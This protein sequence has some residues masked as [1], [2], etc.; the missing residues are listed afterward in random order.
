MAEKNKSH[1][2][3]PVI[4]GY[5]PGAARLIHGEKPKSAWATMKRLTCYLKNDWLL[6]SLAI[7]ASIAVTIFTTYNMRLMGIA[8]DEF[9]VQYNPQGLANIAFTMAIIFT[10]TSFLTYF[11]MRLMNRVSQKVSAELRAD[12]FRSFLC[13]PL[14]FFDRRSSGELMSRLTNDVDN[15]NQTLASGLSS[16]VEAIVNILAMF[17][18]MV[19]LSPYLTAWAMLV[20]PLTF[21]STRIVVS[22]SRRF[23]KTLQ[24]DLGD[25]NAYIE[26]RLSAQKMLILFDQAQT[27]VKGFQR[28]NDKLQI[29]YQNAQTLSALAP[30]MSFINNSI[31]FLVTVVAARMILNGDPMTVGILFT[32]L[33]YMRRFAQPLNQIAS[34]FNSIQSAI[35]GAERIFEIIDTDSEFRDDTLPYV[36]KNGHIA[37]NHVYFSYDKESPVLYDISM[38]IKPGSTLAIVGSTGSGKTTI[39]SLLNRFYD[40]DSG[41]VYLDDQDTLT[42]DH[43]SLRKQVGLVLQDTFLFSDSIRENIRYGCKHASNEDVEKAAEAT[44]AHRFISHLPDGYETIIQENG[45]GLSQGQR[46][47][48]AIS[49]AILSDAPI[50]VLD[51]ATSSID[52][53]TEQEVQEALQTLSSG[54]T[55]LVIAHRL[56]TIRNADRILVLDN[57]R[58]VESGQHDELLASNGIYAAMYRSQFPERISA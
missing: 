50:L 27:T 49:R 20:I 37:Y 24:E 54:K 14:S 32:F 4:G 55:T 52:T 51:E 41:H 10:S 28:L 56:S 47:L 8:I 5:S 15:V 23:F 6:M 7:L 53:R 39:A 9:I 21:I 48:I 13:L 44:G 30:L 33:M 26:E 3:K 42:L 58:I 34:L 22:F 1:H 45:S 18:A 17:V 38:D 11:N 35:A 19:L 12:L 43:R 46:Q 2:E 57:G 36:Y 40:P 29:S 25:T 16:L 31:Y